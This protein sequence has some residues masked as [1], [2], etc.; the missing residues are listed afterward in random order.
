MKWFNIM[1]LRNK[2]LLKCFPDYMIDGIKIS[3]RIKSPHRLEKMFKSK[4]AP[5]TCPVRYYS[6]CRQFKKFDCYELN[7]YVFEVSQDDATIYMLGY[8]Y[9]LAFNKN[10]NLANKLKLHP[11]DFY[12]PEA[13]FKVFYF[14]QKDCSLWLS[15]FTEEIEGGMKDKE[16]EREVRRLSFFQ[17]PRIT[18]ILIPKNLTKSDSSMSDLRF[19]ESRFGY[20][21]YI[22]RYFLIT[23]TSLIIFE[24]EN[25][26]SKIHKIVD[27]KNLGKFERCKYKL[28]S[29]KNGSTIHQRMVMVQY[30]RFRNWRLELFDFEKMEV[31]RQLDF[32]LPEFSVKK[33]IEL[34][35]FEEISSN[36]A[37][38]DKQGDGNKWSLICVVDSF[39]NRYVVANSVEQDGS[40][41]EEYFALQNLV[42]KNG[43]LVSTKIIKS[44]NN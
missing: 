8:G 19:D 23:E 30:N 34:I 36:T 2:K 10:T 33:D 29:E 17:T 20:S 28:L 7:N 44:K 32:S 26:F 21:E 37:H 31:V 11:I 35:Q 25:D 13:G 43:E 4:V 9:K 16:I 22:S 42:D 24:D 38:T 41:G 18:S 39:F 6:S 12:T 3:E 1:G 27:I 5:L 14:N 40:L 15:N